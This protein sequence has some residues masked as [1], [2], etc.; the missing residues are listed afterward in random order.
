MMIVYDELGASA[1]L[2]CANSGAASLVKSRYDDLAGIAA[3]PLDY[4]A[5]P[6]VR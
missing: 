4:E 1:S 2:S 3:E 6:R 5:A